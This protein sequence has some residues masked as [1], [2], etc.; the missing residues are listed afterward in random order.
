MATQF[1]ISTKPVYYEL[2]PDNLL[3]A[4]QNWLHWT[5][6]DCFTWNALVDSYD[7]ERLFSTDPMKGEI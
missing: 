4:L 3:S 1:V 7:V 6:V 5:E 2:F